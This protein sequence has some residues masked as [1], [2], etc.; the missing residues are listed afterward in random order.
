MLQVRAEGLQVRITG[1]VALD[2]R[3]A[4]NRLDDAA[5]QLLDAALAAGRPDGP[6]KILGYD[7]VG[8]LL[9]PEARDFHIA[10]LEDGFAAFVGDHGGSQVPLDL[11]ERIHALL[12]EIALELESGR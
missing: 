3:P 7:D 12:R 11:I 9:R 4:G 8:R 6:A 10:L 1:K 5:D 2:A